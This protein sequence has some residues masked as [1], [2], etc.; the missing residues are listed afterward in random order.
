MRLLSGL[1]S[2]STN[3]MK[4]KRELLFIGKIIGLNKNIGGESKAF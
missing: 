3:L 2:G 1:I 4:T